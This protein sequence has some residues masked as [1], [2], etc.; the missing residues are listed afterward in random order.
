MLLIARLCNFGTNPDRYPSRRSDEEYRSAGKIRNLEG[1]RR[2]NVED[3]F[4]TFKKEKSQFCGRSRK[5]KVR[6]RS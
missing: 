5:K 4:C 3:D 2:T 6:E 1:E